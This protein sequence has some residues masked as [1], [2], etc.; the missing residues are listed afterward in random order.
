M[1]INKALATPLRPKFPV[2]ALGWVSL[3]AVLWLTL[4]A[5]PFAGAEVVVTE[6]A[7]SHLAGHGPVA[8]LSARTQTVRAKGC[9]VPG[10]GSVPFGPGSPRGSI[11][12]QEP[13]RCRGGLT[14]RFLPLLTFDNALPAPGTVTLRA[15]M[16]LLGISGDAAMLG[17]VQLYLQ[18]LGGRNPIVTGTHILVRHGAVVRSATSV[19]RIL[20]RPV[21]GPGI[22]LTLNHPPR[23][24]RAVLDLL[25]E[26]T[27]LKGGRSAL[28]TEEYVT[29]TL[30]Y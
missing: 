13:G 19:A 15:Q 9:A 26:F 2:A 27:V 16:V 3:A 30:T 14:F 7:P 22:S 5:L 1:R 28:F 24:S 18:E 6:A 4:S 20:A 12:I 23:P 10:A 11:L 21:Y 17:N 8:P 25:V 29:V